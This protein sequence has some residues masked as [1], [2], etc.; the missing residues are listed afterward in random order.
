MTDTLQQLP[1]AERLKF[2]TSNLDIN[3]DEAGEGAKA[4]SSTADLQPLYDI[5]TQHQESLKLM[6]K[7]VSVIGERLEQQQYDK[8]AIFESDNLDPLKNKV[9]DIYIE[10]TEKIVELSEKLQ[11]ELAGFTQGR[12]QIEATLQ[13]LKQT[14]VGQAA[15]DDLRDSL[16]TL[17]SESVEQAKEDVVGDQFDV[18]N[19]NTAELHKMLATQAS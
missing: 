9:Q 1:S 11:N 5:V 8:F 18:I 2:E 6:Q 7:E 3:E 13:T 4:S 19:Q 17:V 15:L 10:V 16:V 12:K 14:T